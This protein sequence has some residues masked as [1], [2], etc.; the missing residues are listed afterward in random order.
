MKFGIII[1]N[2]VDDAYRL[3]AENGNTYWTDSI[4]KEMVLVYKYKTF[5]ILEDDEIML[6]GF[7]EIMCHVIF[8]VK[9]DLQQ[10]SRY[11]AG[12]HLVKKQPS[13]NTYSRVV[14]R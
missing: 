3:D 2:T 11:V 8:T 7:Q 14:Y 12:G 9:F 1:P 10:K 13:Y 5:K 4:K 6:P